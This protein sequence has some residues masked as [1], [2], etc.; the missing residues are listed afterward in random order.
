MSD[1]EA[2][3]AQWERDHDREPPR[4]WAGEIPWQEEPVPGSDAAGTDAEFMSEGEWLGC[5]KLDWATGEL[6]AA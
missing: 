4:D 3:R 5:W 6:V 2:T 1:I